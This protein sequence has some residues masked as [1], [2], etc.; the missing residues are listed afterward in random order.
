MNKTEQVFIKQRQKRINKWSIIFIP[1][2]AI[3]VLNVLWLFMKVPNFINPSVIVNEITAQ[4]V[5]QSRLETMAVFLPIVV[6]L[7][8]ILLFVIVGILF[9]SM[10]LEKKYLKIINKLKALNH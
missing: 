3:I 2:I 8:Y 4:V 7:F 9:L 5:K 10:R 6:I 1:L